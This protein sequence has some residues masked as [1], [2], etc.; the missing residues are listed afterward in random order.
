MRWTLKVR[1]MMC[2]FVEKKGLREEVAKQAGTDVKGSESTWQDESAKGEP[3]GPRHPT[4][5]I[6]LIPLLDYRVL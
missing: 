2:F 3:R 5:R 6:K 4:A 1:A